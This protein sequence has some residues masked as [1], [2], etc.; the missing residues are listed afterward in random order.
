MLQPSPYFA[1]ETGH[2]PPKQ[3]LDLWNGLFE[4][5]MELSPPQHGGE[6]NASMT[7]RV[8]GNTIFSKNIGPGFNCHRTKTMV[9][10]GDIDS[11]SL[12]IS[13][14]GRSACHDPKRLVAPGDIMFLDYARSFDYQFQGGNVA[15]NVLMINRK[16]LSEHISHVDELHGLH[17]TSKQGQA[18]LLTRTLKI[19]G[20]SLPQMDESDGDCVSDLI[21]QILAACLRPQNART[22]VQRTALLDAKRL[23][24][25]SF[26]ES[27]LRNPG[28]TP[29]YICAH[30]GLSQSSLY[31]LFPDQGGIA[32]Y[33]WSRRLDLAAHD[34]RDPMKTHL[35]LGSIALQL[36]FVQQSHFSMAFKRRFGMNAKDWRQAARVGHAI[37]HFDAASTN[38]SFYLA[39]MLRQASLQYGTH[40]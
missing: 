34:L 11:I 12:S 30:I 35:T 3:R 17:W 6:F 10:R 15:M 9:A 36:G 4:S 19:V 27:N 29:A 7:A 38:S 21:T 14:V 23:M 5:V 13:S 22:D 31:S 33:I 18:R 39:Q 26:I 25:R 2:V 37:S 20:R 16:A 1:T 28:L 24:I 32:H 40:S 8:V